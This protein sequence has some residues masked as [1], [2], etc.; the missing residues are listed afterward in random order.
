MPTATLPTS[1]S[2]AIASTIST[3]AWGTICPNI[4]IGTKWAETRSTSREGTV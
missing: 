3:P 2:P 1:T 4:A